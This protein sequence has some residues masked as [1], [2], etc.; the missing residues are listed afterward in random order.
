MENKGKKWIAMLIGL[1]IFAG[2]GYLLMPV[3]YSFTHSS[4]DRQ[5]IEKVCDEMFGTTSLMDALTEE[6]MI[7]SYDYNNRTPRI[8]TKYGANLYPE[9]FL[10]SLSNAS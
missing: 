2:L 5:G 3:L 6:V 9:L 4:Y 7:V 10:T 8:F 1:F